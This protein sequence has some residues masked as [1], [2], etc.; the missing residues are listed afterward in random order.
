[1]PGLAYCVN[2]YTILS[3]V[4]LVVAHEELL[5]L[6]EWRH[7]HCFRLEEIEPTE[8][9]F[10]FLLHTAVHLRTISCGRLSALATSGNFF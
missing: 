7:F 9:H 4:E 1:M 10:F 5:G 3:N 6:E 2:K 8:A